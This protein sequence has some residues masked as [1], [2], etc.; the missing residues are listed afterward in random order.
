MATVPRVRSTDSPTGFVDAVF[1]LGPEL[2]MASG[3][4]R[5][6]Y[7]ERVTRGGFPSPRGRPRRTH[8]RPARPR[9][10]ARRPWQIAQ[11]WPDAE[12]HLVRREHT[13][14]DEMS[15]RSSDTYEQ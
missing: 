12:L 7:I 8:P 14:N 11:R 3:E 1:K 5:S 2:G 9:R 15:K 10:A 4:E 13:G 6:H